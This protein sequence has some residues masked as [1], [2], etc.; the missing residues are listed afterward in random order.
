MSFISPQIFTECCS[1]PG[2]MLD[3]REVAIPE[4]ILPWSL[5]SS[6]ILDLQA[7]LHLALSVGAGRPV[8]C[9]QRTCRR[10][11]LCTSVSSWGEGQKSFVD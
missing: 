3:N 9:M 1:V 11:H 8:T 4:V 6:G 2:I 10:I 7:D 5:R